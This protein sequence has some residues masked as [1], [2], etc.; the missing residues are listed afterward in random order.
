MKIALDS[1]PILK[2]KTGIGWYT[3]MIMKELNKMDV[4]EQ[5]VSLAFDFR[6]RNRAERILR[7]LGFND[8]FIQKKL[9]YKL[10]KMLWSILP[11][12]YNKLFK[13]YDVY[14]FFNYIIPPFSKAKVITTIHD[15]AFVK[16]PETMRWKTLWHLKLRIRYSLKKA[17]HIIVISKSTKSDLIENFDVNPQ[18]ISVVPCAVD[19]NIYNVGDVVEL[20]EQIRKKYDLPNRFF[21]YLGTVEPRKNIERLIKAYSKLPLELRCEMKLVIAGG[22]GWKCE[23]IYA[24]PQKLNVEKDVLFTGYID[25]EDKPYI[26]NLS[27]IFLFPSLYEG[28][29][30]PILE[31]MASGTPVI[32]SSVSSMPEVS[33]GAAVLVNP[34]DVEVL[35][36]AMLELSNDPEKRDKLIQK[37][38]RRVHAYS[39]KESA[40]I[41]L[42]VFK[43]VSEDRC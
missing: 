5:F 42:N 16:C 19:C 18:K 38:Y 7:N 41:L 27:E 20:R 29:G 17:D 13:G 12:P 31:A 39:W 23:Q 33:G 10:Y 30:I 37:G 24:L 25:E 36:D 34:L 22:K 14:H 26:Y 11:I 4:E 35:S 8:Y 21:L 6:G 9:P 15:L 40:E 2:Q 1:Q 32:T 43:N 3:Y 28:F